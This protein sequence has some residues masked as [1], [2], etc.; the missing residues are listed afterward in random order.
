MGRKAQDKLKEKIA[1]LKEEI[2]RLEKENAEKDEL[3]KKLKK[4]LKAL[5]G[6]GGGDDEAR[7]WKYKYEGG[8]EKFAELEGKHEALEHKVA[9]LIEKLR[10]YGG[11][12]AVQ[13]S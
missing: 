11:E 7:K 10:Q 5:E 12:E 3:I 9:L 6:A 8:L 4:D 1:D 2:E 13:Q